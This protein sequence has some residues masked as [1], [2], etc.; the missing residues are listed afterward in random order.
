MKCFLIG[1]LGCNT[2]G[3]SS[4]YVKKMVYLLHC[5]SFLE[6]I[7]EYDGTRFY[8]LHRCGVGSTLAADIVRG[9]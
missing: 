8:A 4:G 9:C 5:L 7:S 1:A 3:I 6:D 2:S